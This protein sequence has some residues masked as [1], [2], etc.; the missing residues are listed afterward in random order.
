MPSVLSPAGSSCVFGVFCKGGLVGE[1]VCRRGSSGAPANDAE[2]AGNNSGSLNFMVVGLHVASA[3]RG[4]FRAL[5]CW[6]DV[7]WFES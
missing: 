7:F 4:G 5:Q 2:G 6:G 1:E 3:S